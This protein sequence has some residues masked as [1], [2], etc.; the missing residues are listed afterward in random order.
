MGYRSIEQARGVYYQGLGTFTNYS[1][2]NKTKMT[3]AINSVRRAAQY[4]KQSGHPELAQKWGKVADTIKIISEGGRPKTMPTDLANVYKAAGISPTTKQRSE[5]ERTSGVGLTKTYGQRRGKDLASLPLSAK[6]Y[7]AKY[8]AHEL[9]KQGIAAMKAGD[10]GRAIDLFEKQI[11]YAHMAGYK[12]EY[13]VPMGRN[14]QVAYERWTAQKKGIPATATRMPAA[15]PSRQG[16]TASTTRR[17]DGRTYHLQS[18]KTGTTN[19]RVVK[20]KVRL[21]KQ[22]HR[23]VRVVKD[24]S[25]RKF[26]YATK[27]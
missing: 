24:G 3:L 13:I 26:V 6:Q 19:G 16:P 2:K 8:K 14:K 12:A 21:R 15:V 7:S 17:I 27:R 11:G 10:Y 22:G 1:W 18:P 20:I 5:W 25:G 9:G 4:A 23:S